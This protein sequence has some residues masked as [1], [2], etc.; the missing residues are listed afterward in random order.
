VTQRDENGRER[1]D[2]A[3]DGTGQTGTGRD[4]TGRDG[5][6][7]IL[8][9]MSAFGNGMGTDLYQRTGCDF[10]SCVPL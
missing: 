8:I 6:E 7:T 1:L 4:G 5:T 9:S 2:S 3:R 10:H